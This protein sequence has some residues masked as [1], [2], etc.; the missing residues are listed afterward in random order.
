M[1]ELRFAL[2]IL[3]R[4]IFYPLIHENVLTY[5]NAFNMKTVLK[6]TWRKDPCV[7]IDVVHHNEGPS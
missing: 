7:Q 6:G 2:M 3:N 4:K 1:Y 5:G